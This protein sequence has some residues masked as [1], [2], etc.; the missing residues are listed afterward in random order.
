[1]ANY[2]RDVAN[3]AGIDV[4]G[5][6]AD[7]SLAD[8]TKNLASQRARDIM[9]AMQG[10]YSR[11]SEQ[12]YND[13]YF[14]GIERGLSPR[15]AQKVAEALKGNYQA[16]RVNY[17]DGL[18]NSYGRDGLVMNDYGNSAIADLISEDPQRASFYA[19]I[20]PNAKEAFTRYN[21]LEDANIKQRN[22]L[23]Q[24]AVGNQYDLGRIQAQTAGNIEYANA[25]H[26]NTLQRDAIQHGYDKE[27]ARDQYNFSTWLA[28]NQ[29]KIDAEL[30]KLAADLELGNATYLADYKLQL[31]DKDFQQ[32]VAQFSAFADY[33]GYEGEGKKAFLTAAFGIKL[34][35]ENTGKFDK[36]S[37]ENGKKLHDMLD[38]DEDKILK[39][40]E[41]EL[42]P[43][44]VAELQGKL[45]DIRQF[46]QQLENTMGEQIGVRGGVQEFTGNEATDNA[47]LAY[48]W[49][50]A[51][52]DMD[53]FKGYVSN[54]LDQSG[55]TLKFKE[56]YLKNLK[57]P[58]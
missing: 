29:G 27:N 21:A 17:L 38:A 11:N 4:S 39:Q 53:K 13:E 36:T 44:K 5:Y 56:G 41:S 43:Q 37:I 50:Y 12:Y 7:V 48:L 2:L 25:T 55:V 10:Y 35:D 33:L 18:L 28:R 40:I 47:T 19:T 31:Q 49:N 34:P 3:A 26:E 22:E 54:W 52:G 51:N 46:K 1:Q 15:K 57:A 23:E 6:G 42:D 16:E 30:K 58:Q 8:A 14:R 24:L 45:I 20:Y 9:A 32:K